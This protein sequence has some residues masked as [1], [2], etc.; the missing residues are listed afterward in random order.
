MGH[1]D[2]KTTEVY[3]R[4]AGIDLKAAHRKSHPREKEREEN[5]KPALERIRPPYERKPRPCEP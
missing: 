3:L 1:A 4:T 5:I 2:L